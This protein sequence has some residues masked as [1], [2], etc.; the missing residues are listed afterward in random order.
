VPSSA[1]APLVVV[2]LRSEAAHLGGRGPLVAGAGGCHRPAHRC[3][4]GRPRL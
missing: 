3:R 2:A 1:G 4:R